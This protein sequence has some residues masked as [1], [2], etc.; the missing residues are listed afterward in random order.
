MNNTKLSKEWFA[1]ANNDFRAVEISLLTPYSVEIRYP[2]YFE[3]I[4]EANEAYKLALKTK[5]F[6]TLKLNL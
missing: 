2:D 6:I 1:K 4:E 3:E 5:E